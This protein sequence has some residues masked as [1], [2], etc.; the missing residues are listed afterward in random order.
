MWRNSLFES[1]FWRSWCLLLHISLSSSTICAQEVYFNKIYSNPSYHFNIGLGVTVLA[2]GNYFSA[3]QISPYS[4]NNGTLVSE[5]DSRGEVIRQIEY[6]D[7]LHTVSPSYPATPI[8]INNKIYYS[9]FRRIS[10]PMVHGVL[11]EYKDGVLH[12]LATCLFQD[13]VSSSM[14]AIIP[15]RNDICL[16]GHS[17]KHLGPTSTFSYR[18]QLY[19]SEYDTLGNKKWDNTYVAE[20]GYYHVYGFSVD[21][22]DDNGYIVGG[23]AEYD[24]VDKR[25]SGAFV[26]LTDSV[27]NKRAVRYFP[28]DSLGNTPAH[29]RQ[30][31]NGNYLATY[32]H[33]YQALYGNRG[34]IQSWY[35]TREVVITE[36]E[37]N[38]LET[39]WEKR[40]LKKGWLNSLW[41]NSLIQQNDSTYL[42]FGD[43]LGQ[44]GNYEPHPAPGW[45]YS[46]DKSGDSL[47]YRELAHKEGYSERHYVWGGSLTPDGGLLMG[48][49]TEIDTTGASGLRTW[50]IKVDSIGCPYPGCDTVYYKEVVAY[51]LFPNPTTG[52]LTLEL[53]DTEYVDITLF[54][55]NG[56]IVLQKRLVLD[57]DAVKFNIHDNSVLPTGMYLLQLITDNGYRINE[58]LIVTND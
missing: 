54:D 27:G 16:V 58:K 12:E 5:Y 18:E 35:R 57:H 6:V 3:E 21:T 2:N 25:F 45:I 36:L 52:E 37:R 51:K 33:S 11:F 17:F 24:P 32:T 48:G 47:W 10:G 13:S 14:R 41:I 9:A 8:E 38:T 29:V 50:L 34:R 19:V 26:L 53:P 7:T 42:I 43:R 56:R 4:G 30:L 49:Y 28:N 22:T 40:V 1:N 39:V 44:A 23:M 15:V 31:A 55:P 46:F 20:N